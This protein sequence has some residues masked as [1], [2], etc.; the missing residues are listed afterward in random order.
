[1][2]KINRGAARLGRRAGLPFRARMGGASAARA[3]SILAPIGRIG[4][5]VPRPKCR[6]ADSGR[7]RELT[8]AR[9]PRPARPSRPGGA[10]A[11][12]ADVRMM[13]QLARKSARAPAPHA[14]HSSPFVSF[15]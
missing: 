6:G 15:H 9:R 11:A 4:E 7:A 12:A 8:G 13:K 5:P 2:S 14:P 10:A 1:M 3:E